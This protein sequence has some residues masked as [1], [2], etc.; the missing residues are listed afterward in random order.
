MSIWALSDFHLSFGLPNKS[1]E[2]FGPAWEKW[3]SRIKSSC[4]EL[5]KPEDLLLIAGDISW[6]TTLE[7][8]QADLQWIDEL[9]GTKVLLKGNHDYWWPSLKKLQE[10]LPPSVF[11][12]QHTCF[13]WNEISITGTRL[14]DS[15]EFS[16]ASLSSN[17]ASLIEPIKAFSDEDKKIYDREIGRLEL[18]LKSLSPSSQKKIV[19]T[20]YPPIGLDLKETKASKLFDEYGI[21]V[22]IFGHLHNIA[23]NTPLFGKANKTHYLLTSCDYLNCRPIKIF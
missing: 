2:V 5:I 23:C 9:P 7:E 4:Q 19:M 3:T 8:A 6:A 12:V 17:S 22:V 15:P 21:D 14:W 10:V 20:H 18:A 13:D 16:F 1:M 11:A